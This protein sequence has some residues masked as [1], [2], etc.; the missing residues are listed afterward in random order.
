LS[1]FTEALLARRRK[2]AN[3]EHFWRAWLVRL[4][5][6]VFVLQVVGLFAA[7]ARPAPAGA[8]SVA[9]MGMPDCP[10]HSA[11]GKGHDNGAPDSCP[12]CQTL[13]FALAGASL[14][15][16]VTRAN[17]RLI[18]LLAVPAPQAAPRAP[19]LQSPP[20]RGPPVLV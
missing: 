3:S 4:T 17:E 7:P 13:G 12:M 1:P 11:H 5:A 18:G 20:P 15:S 8:D 14:P 6:L 19:P 9:E 16:L 10:H 2:Q